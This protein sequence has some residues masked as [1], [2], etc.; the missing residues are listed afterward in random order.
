MP[1]YLVPGF[2]TGLW[3]RLEACAAFSMED[4]AGLPC[5]KTLISAILGNA[6][7][8]IVPSD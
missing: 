1:R 5:L 7:Q 3:H 4:Q 6:I 2:Q 8:M